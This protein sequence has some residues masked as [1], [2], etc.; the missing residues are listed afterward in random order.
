MSNLYHPLFFVG[1]SDVT[2]YCV[3]PGP[4]NVNSCSVVV[5][6]SALTPRYVNT[7]ASGVTPCCDYVEVCSV[8]A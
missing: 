2:S 6:A 1:V 7:G 3:Y 4:S 8:S 5:G